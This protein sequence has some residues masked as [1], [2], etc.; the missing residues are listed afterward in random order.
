MRE[1]FIT[2]ETRA[3][4]ILERAIENMIPTTSR[5]LSGESRNIQ[6]ASARLTAHNYRKRVL[7]H[8]NVQ[9]AFE[10][11]GNNL[12][13]EMKYTLP[14]ASLSRENLLTILSE[15]SQFSTFNHQQ[16]SS[17]LDITNAL[18]SDFKSLT[19][20]LSHRIGTGEEIVATLKTS[21]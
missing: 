21:P 9:K 17:E 13:D 10:K 6:S 15:S 14:D 4:Q 8:A 18:V 20:V 1:F 2:Q 16:T 19:N 3:T 7:S 11:F 5:H 12:M